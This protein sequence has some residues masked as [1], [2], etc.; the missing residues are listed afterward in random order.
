M[1]TTVILEY[2]VKN[3]GN[4]LKNKGKCGKVPNIYTVSSVIE[5]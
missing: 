3:K 4:K 1:D 2:F 5:H